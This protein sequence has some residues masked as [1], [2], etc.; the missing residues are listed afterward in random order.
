MNVILS[1]NEIINISNDTTYSI[2]IE[3]NNKIRCIEKDNVKFEYSKTISKVSITGSVIWTFR[4]DT[5][6]M[7]GDSNLCSITSF[8]VNNDINHNSW[9]F[10]DSNIKI[11]NGCIYVKGSFKYNFLWYTIQTINIDIGFCC[12][13]DG[14]IIKV[15][16]FV[17]F[18][19]FYKIYLWT[20]H[21][22]N[23]L[24]DVKFI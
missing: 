16:W 9:S 8:Y 17:D 19:Y 5:T 15:D 4:I 22:T 6:F 18:F 23:I 21:L 11:V 1:K 20:I 12:S 10:S 13:K 14:T 2:N 24:Y 3:E 7:A